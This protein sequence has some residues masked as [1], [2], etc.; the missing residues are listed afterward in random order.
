[1]VDVWLAHQ[2]IT[3]MVENQADLYNYIA[4]ETINNTY[5]RF[6]MRSAEGRRKTIV[7]SDDETFDDDKPLFIRIKSATRCGV[8]LHVSL[9]KKRS[10]KRDRT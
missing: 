9:T 10:K 6:M 4:E 2:E 8:Y 5:N 7:D 1:M 3:G